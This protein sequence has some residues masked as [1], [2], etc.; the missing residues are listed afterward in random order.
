[1]NF[2]SYLSPRALNTTKNV[3]EFFPP[4]P[5]LPNRLQ[6]CVCHFRIIDDET[7]LSIIWSIHLSS[8]T[9]WTFKTEWPDTQTLLSYKGL[10][11]HTLCA[12]IAAAVNPLHRQSPHAVWHGLPTYA[13][14]R[15]NNR[16]PAAIFPVTA[17]ETVGN[18]RCST[19]II[20]TI[21]VQIPPVD[22][23]VNK[24]MICRRWW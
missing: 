10:P 2:Y 23:V 8:V 18:F 14:F 15:E 13:N 12:V 3:S 21:S 9:G 11:R 1:M 6:N 19:R 7:D 4:P 5:H 24:I 16:L 22:W 20:I 17:D